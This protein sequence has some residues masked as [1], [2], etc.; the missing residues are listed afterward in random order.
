MPFTYALTTA[1]DA[2]ASP[3]LL[4]AAQ[5]AFGDRIWSLRPEATAAEA[6]PT[7]LTS[8]TGFGFPLLDLFDA[9]QQVFVS[10]ADA[11]AG[12]EPWVV[13]PAAPGGARRIAD[14]N[15]TAGPAPGYNPEQNTAAPNAFE[16]MV[17]SSG[18][19]AWG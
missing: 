4:F 17:N 18:D 14:I 6:T 11:T 7:K 15:T 5:D 2:P 1:P 19:W 12:R 16:D 8:V 13:D 9:D 3:L 10:N